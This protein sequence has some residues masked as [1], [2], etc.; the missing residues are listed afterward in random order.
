MSA[1]LEPL[2]HEECLERLA[3]ETVGRMAVLHEGYPVVVPVSYRLVERDGVHVIAVR[4][5]PG[6]LLDHPGAAVG[7]EIDA[8]GNDRRSGW[9]VLVRGVL[10]VVE[11]DEVPD[12]G[13]ACAADRDAWRVVVPWMITGRRLPSDASPWP[14]D[15]EGYL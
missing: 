11:P 13:P 5:R 6:N 10:R 1:T 8:V 15:P 4:T 14:F 3:A 2:S 12:P 7:F 9:S